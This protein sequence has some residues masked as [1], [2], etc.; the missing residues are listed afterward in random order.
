MLIAILAV[1]ALCWCPL[2]ITILYSEYRGN[3]TEPVSL[4]KQIIPDY[5]FCSLSG[6]YILVQQNNFWYEL[7]E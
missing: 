2:Q 5:Y 3:H 1:F 6:K 4:T 7:L